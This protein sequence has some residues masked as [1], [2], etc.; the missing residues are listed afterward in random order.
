MKTGKIVI[1]MAFTLI[2]IRVVILLGEP[3]GSGKTRTSKAVIASEKMARLIA[4]MNN[5]RHEGEVLNFEQSK[6]R[7]ASQF[8]LEASTF[9]TDIE[10]AQIQENERTGMLVEVDYYLFMKDPNFGLL[11]NGRL[12]RGD[13]DKERLKHISMNQDIS[14]MMK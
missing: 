11:C 13:F 5:E 2:L 1:L 9:F 12:F 3:W 8:A 6:R 4:F 7:F 14:K 10:F